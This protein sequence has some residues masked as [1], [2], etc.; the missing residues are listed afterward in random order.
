MYLATMTAARFTRKQYMCFTPLCHMSS[1]NMNY[2]FD[3]GSSFCTSKDY[4]M[5]SYQDIDLIKF[6]LQK[7]SQ[8]ARI[9]A[10]L[11][12]RVISLGVVILKNFRYSPSMS[13]RKNLPIANW[14]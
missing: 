3:K 13:S 7:T 11:R 12:S 1:T 9:G 5:K 10:Q 2:W 6:S 14:S 4:T 8:A